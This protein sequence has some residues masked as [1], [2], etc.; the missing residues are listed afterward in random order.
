MCTN[1]L[2]PRIARQKP[3]KHS[4]PF[5]FYGESIQNRDRECIYID[6]ENRTYEEEDKDIGVSS[7]G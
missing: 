2:Q 7:P 4:S 5:C 6:N 3:T 1:K